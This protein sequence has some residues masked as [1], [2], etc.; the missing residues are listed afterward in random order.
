MF[1]TIRWRRLPQLVRLL[2]LHGTIGF[3]IA[4]LFMARFLVVDPGDARH[5][6]LGSAG[7]WWPALVLWF[8]LG[9]TSGSVQM[10]VAVRLLADRPPPPGGGHRAR[11]LRL[12]LVPIPI[13]RSRRGWQAFKAPPDFSAACQTFSTS[14]VECGASASRFSRR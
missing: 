3:G 5:L 14:A 10:G 13:T 11:I 7:H 12:E 2:I 8:F 1:L 4:A 6:L 9:L